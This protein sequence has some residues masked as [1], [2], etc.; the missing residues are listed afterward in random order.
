MGRAIFIGQIIEDHK[1]VGHRQERSVTFC[2]EKP[3]NCVDLAIGSALSTM[4]PSTPRGCHAPT[5]RIQRAES[6]TTNGVASASANLTSLARRLGP[7]FARRAIRRL[8]S[9][10]KGPN[11]LIYV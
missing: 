8:R 10:P 7:L 2:D 6:A 4:C 3:W 1:R 9:R 5:P 11:R